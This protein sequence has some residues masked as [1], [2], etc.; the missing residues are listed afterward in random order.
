MVMRVFVAGGTGV[1]G[2]RLV[3][4]LA[5]LL[6]ASAGL[7]GCGSE[8][9]AAEAPTRSV[10]ATCLNDDEV[11]TGA[12]EFT[13][14]AGEELEGYQ[15]GTGDTGVVLAHQSDGNLCQW[16]AYASTLARQGYRT[17]IFTFKDALDQDVVAAVE[18]IRR[19][20]AKRVILIG[21]SMG[22]TASVVAAADATLFV[23]GLIVLSAPTGYQNIDAL[24]EA[25]KLTMPLLLIAGD[26]DALYSEQARKLR[27]AATKAPERKLLVVKSAG[28]GVDL[29]SG[30]VQQ[31]IEDFLRAHATP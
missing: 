12:V 13:T 22:G 5:A 28:H 7:V 24:A 25:P 8:D 6:L 3:P 14:S 29:V 26:Q 23:D 31:A 15:Q 16:K 17:L 19:A 4:Q 9:G 20:G 30:D 1:I 10:A 18:Q 21:A 11:R 27:D 2:R